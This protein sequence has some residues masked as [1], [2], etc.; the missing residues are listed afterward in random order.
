MPAV[1]NIATMQNSEVTVDKLDV[2]LTE[3]VTDPSQTKTEH[4]NRS[5]GI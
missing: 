4:I 5:T 3:S 2:G 1:T